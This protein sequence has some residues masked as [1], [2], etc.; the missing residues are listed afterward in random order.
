MK[1]EAGRIAAVLAALVLGMS[2]SCANNM[3]PGPPEAGRSMQVTVE[4]ISFTMRYVPEGS[5]Q[6]DGDSK[7]ISI[8][9]KAYWMMET[10]VTQ[11]LYQKV[12]G[13]NPGN[14]KSDPQFLLPV[15]QVSWYDALEFCNALSLIT[16]K[17][18]VYTIMNRTPSGGSP[19]SSADVAV[20][21]NKN[22]YCLPTEMEWMW[23]AMGADKSVPP[24]TKGYDKKFAGY[25]DGA[26]L[27]NYVWYG[28]N[29]ESK[30]HPVRDRLPNELGLYDMSG[31]VLEWCWD[32]YNTTYKP[33]TLVNSPDPAP[34][35]STTHVIR[36]GSW[37][38]PDTDCSIA[39]R[40]Y[41]PPN[42]VSSDVGFRV[43]C[44]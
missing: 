31:N 10:E 19:I 16:G 44:R 14:F 1:E 4:G 13:Y 26:E 20:N 7:N 28:V 23:A 24:S 40:K 8:I 25:K 21:V 9:T 15:E 29:A 6:R 34:N 38:D 12:I 36:G 27:G 2:L 32:W 37:K 5:F 41:S 11:A 33:G 30:T 18:P 3:D 42:A 39:F 17:E 43:V 35:G 22:G